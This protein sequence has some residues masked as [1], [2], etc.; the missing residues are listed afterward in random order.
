MT[1]QAWDAVLY[2]GK[3]GFVTELGRALIDLLAPQPGERVLDLGCGTGDLAATI[4]ARGASVVGLDASPDMLAA[5]RAKYPALEVVQGDA[6]GFQFAES[7]DAVFSNAVLHWVADADGVA[8]S[9]AAALKPGGRFVAELGG[10]GNIAAIVDGV[11]R[12][13]VDVAGVEVERRQFYP[14]VGEYAGLLERHGLE[15]R[16]AW[17][18]DRPTKLADGDRGLCNWVAMF[19]PDLPVPVDRLEAVLNRAEALLRPRLFRDGAWFADYRRLRIIA[20]RVV[21]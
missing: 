3:H 15:V 14:S 2:D 8:R 20:V 17:L 19:W 6:A 18:F 13:A 10:R 5:A 7:F 21:E 1:R 11:R 9:V 16:S 12:A 4:A